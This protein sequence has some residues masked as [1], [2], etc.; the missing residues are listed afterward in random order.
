MAKKQKSGL[1][2]GLNS[3]LGESM[4]EVAPVTEVPET[5]T[6]VKDQIQ[7]SFKEAA[8]VQ[9]NGFTGELPIEVIFPNPDQPRVNFSEDEL[10]ELAESIKD[11]GLLQPIL[12][13]P[14][15]ENYQIVAGERRYQAC[16]KLGLKKIPVRIKEI[17]Q[18]KVL[19]LAIIEN[20]QRSDLNP[21]EEAYGYRQLME[22][23]GMT[24]AE[25]AKLMSKGRSTIANALRLLDLPEDAQKLLYEGEITA[26]HARAILSIDS[27]EGKNK[28][29]QALIANKMSVREAE[30]YARLISAQEKRGENPVVH[31]G[32]PKS[33]KRAA[34]GLKTTLDTKVRVRTVKGKNK[35]EIEF[36]D[37]DDLERILGK[38]THE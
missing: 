38:I 23:R 16:M 4:G 13:R 5:Y 8:V 11:H 10:N 3:I 21:I 18:E 14:L 22:E 6:E 28:L 34:Q 12:V 33:F 26:G 9:E 36:K 29:T 27:L 2:R 25:V 7:Q 24:Q 19:E 1:G 30:A 15:G 31:T 17:P 37:E 35:I 32:I 20:I